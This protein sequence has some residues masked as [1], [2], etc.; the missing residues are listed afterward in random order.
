MHY[1]QYREYLCSRTWRQHRLVKL[2]AANWRCEH[3]GEAGRL[4]VHHLTY[5]RLGREYS[6]DLIVL[7]T[8]CHW[9]ADEMRQNPN[10]DLRQRYEAPQKPKLEMSKEERKVEQHK[11]R[12]EGNY[13][14]RFGGQWASRRKRK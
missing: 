13:H 8:P 2:E 3:C 4:S 1:K 6:S 11:R 10:G 14:Y 12:R 9:V 7:C 5:E